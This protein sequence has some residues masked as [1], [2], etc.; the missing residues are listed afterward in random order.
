MKEGRNYMEAFFVSLNT[1]VKEPE[2][3]YA[4]THTTKERE[5]LEEHLQKVQYYF[6]RL[7]EEKQL[8]HI[9]HNFKEVL[10]ESVY[11]EELLVGAL[12]LH[13]IGKVNLNFQDKQMENKYFKHKNKGYT[14]H[15]ILSSLIYIDYYMEQFRVQKLSKST[16]CKIVPILILNA[17]VISRHHSD[18]SSLSKFE[19][20]LKEVYEKVQEDESLTRQLIKPVTIKFKAIKSLLDLTE[21][22]L[23]S[24][25]KEWEIAGPYIYTRW[26]YSLLVACDFYATSDYMEGECV[27][28]IGMLQ[29]K[30]VWQTT[31]EHTVIYNKIQEY[32]ANREKVNIEQSTSIN[33]LR[34]ELFLEATEHLK[35]EPNAPIYYLEAPTGS[36]KTNTSIHLTLEL[37]KQDTRLEKI[38]YVFPFNTLAEQTYNSLTETFQNNPDI[39]NQITVINSI[40]PIKNKQEKDKEEKQLEDIDYSRMLLDRQFLHYPLVITSHIQLFNLLFNP[41]REQ[42]GGLYQLC[43]SVIIIDEVQSY[44]NTLWTEIIGFLKQYAKLLNIRIL[45]MSATLPPLGE[46]IGATDIVPLIQNRDCYFK[47]RL[48]K[49]RVHLDFSL[50]NEGDV[51]EAIMSKILEIGKGKKKILVE[52]IKKKS[53]VHFYNEIVAMKEAGEI[54]QE[55]MLITGDDFKWERE[56]CIKQVKRSENVLLIATQV[57]EAGVDIDMDIGFKDISLLDAE[58][59]FLGRINR[60]CLKQDCKVYFFNLDEAATIYRGDYRKQK[61]FTLLEE[62]NQQYLIDKDFKTYYKGILEEVKQFGMSQNTHNLERFLKEE[63]GGLESQNVHKHMQLIDEDT[64]MIS[65]FLARQVTIYNKEVELTLDGVEIWEEYRALLR[66][67][68]MPY[69]RRKVELSKLREWM[70]CF[71]WKVRYTGQAYNERIGDLYFIEEGEKYFT[72]GKFDREKLSES[73]YELL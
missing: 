1:L 45:I 55:I 54:E 61:R 7:R 23:K 50:L 70:T 5:L 14:D 12:Y 9:I 11:F 22:F 52:F 48:F 68:S 10:G 46:L 73:S 6:E 19:E 59:Q 17:Y 67:K 30:E 8:E 28:D 24:Q 3:L 32:K 20:A 72:N 15:A 63:V 51:L 53:A 57:I 71:I 21:T 42:A 49:E 41:S 26:L 25:R 27:E 43:N 39:T 18:L 4:H 35:Q 47:H 31:Y 56:A 69:A 34:S 66:D 60:S 16:M 40:T 64:D 62:Q 58:E 29:D 38:F 36:G 33:V 2:H 44:K 13:D 37:M 65:I